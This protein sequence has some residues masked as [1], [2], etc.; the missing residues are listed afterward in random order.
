MGRLT[1]VACREALTRSRLS[2]KEIVC[3]AAAFF[4]SR[5]IEVRQFSGQIVLRI[6]FA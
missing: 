4:A 1:N 2:A 5:A 3:D 6:V